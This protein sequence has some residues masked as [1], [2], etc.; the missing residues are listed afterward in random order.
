[1]KTLRCLC[2]LACAGLVARPAP[3]QDVQFLMVKPGDPSAT[4]TMAK[5]FLDDMA[6]YLSSRVDA[7]SGRTVGGLISN[8][9]SSAAEIIGS[10]RPAIVFCPA[11]FYLGYLRTLGRATPVAELH[12]FGAVA[13]QY[14]LVSSSNGPASLEEA[15]KG[16]IIATADFDEAYLDRVVFPAGASRSG[17]LPIAASENVSDDVFLLLEGDPA[18]GSTSLLLDTELRSLFESDD[19]VWPE[20]RVV[21][22]SAALPRDL[23][24]AIGADWDEQE[25]TDLEAALRDMP[26]IAE[27]SRIL[28]L[29]SS[30]GFVSVDR[31]RLERATELYD[32]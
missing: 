27:G 2:L 17:P 19:L 5:D 14:V 11:S 4:E 20:L 21:W 13:E 30:D 23:V 12:R 26:D 7:F 1:M 15:L 32:R 25:L 22:E 3:A 9:T 24:V 6:A 28:E 31:N 10:R 8:R 18:S 16:H 29:M